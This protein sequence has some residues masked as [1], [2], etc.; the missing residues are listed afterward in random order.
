MNPWVYLMLGIL[1]E[2][3]GTSSLKL[4]N[5]FTEPPAFSFDRIIF[6][7][8]SILGFPQC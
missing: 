1:F 4:S 6:C 7:Y 5:G 3:A 2:A 8:F